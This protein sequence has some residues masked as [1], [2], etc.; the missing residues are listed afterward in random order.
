MTYMVLKKKY[1]FIR[2]ASK[3][4]ERDINCFSGNAVLKNHQ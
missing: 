4:T 2:Q 1:M 3:K